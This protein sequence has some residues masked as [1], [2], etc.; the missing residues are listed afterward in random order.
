VRES[1][2]AFLDSDRA[3][4]SVVLVRLAHDDAAGSAPQ[5]PRMLM[6]QVRQHRIDV[7]DHGN[8]SFPPPSFFCPTWH[9]PPLS[10]M[11]VR[12][13]H[14]RYSLFSFREILPFDNYIQWGLFRSSTG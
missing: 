6:R 3:G 1:F 2:G 13:T 10:S 11:Y 8:G 4:N 14:G 7:V 12:Y 5:N 9:H